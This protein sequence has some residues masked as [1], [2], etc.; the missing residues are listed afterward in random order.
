MKT[1]ILIL[2][3]IICSACANKEVNNTNNDIDSISSEYK[4]YVE[5]F[6]NWYKNQIICNFFI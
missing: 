2:S 1:I 6:Q 3:F 4:V 5:R